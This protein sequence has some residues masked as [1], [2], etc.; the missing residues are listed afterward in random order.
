MKVALISRSSLF[1]VKGGDTTQI[2]KTSDELNKLGVQTDIKLANENINYQDYDLLHFFNLIRPADHLYHIRK[3]GKPYV[4]STIYL[5]YTE[6]D[7]K[8]R[9]FF[10]RNLF[11]T[12][13]KHPSE[14]LKNC[15]RYYKNQ[16][17]LV[18]YSYLKGH[19]KA[20]KLVARD[21]ALM[22]PNSHTEYERVL[23]DIGI[24]KDYVVVPNGIDPG[25]FGKIPAGIPR[26][27]TVCCVGQIYGM[28]NQLKLIKACSELKVPLKLIGKSPPNHKKYYRQCHQ[29]KNST[30]E[31]VEFMPQT[32]LLKF[33]AESRVHALPSWFE[34]TGLSSLEAGAMGCN[35][36]VGE[37]G[38]TRE[39]FDGYASFCDAADLKSIRLALEEAL[40][41]P[42]T[43]ELADVIR[44]KYTWRKAAER[45][46][47]AYE[48]ALE[49]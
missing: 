23:N 2:S 9:S 12:L 47:E 45:T 14:L 11:R 41:K 20:M 4:L 33:Y 35:L 10:Y 49:F 39:Y 43:S 6:F 44:E 3:S 7:R 28:K 36:V 27:G 29:I 21:A 30:A 8:G 26:K 17:E 15:Y 37:G 42:T 13:G 31:F 48:K 46:L 40:D 32:E 5:D 16:D 19:L 34:T 1:K 18:T 24:E 25:I 38:D 22:L